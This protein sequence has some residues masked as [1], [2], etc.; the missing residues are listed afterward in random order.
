[1]D[2]SVIRFSNQSQEPIKA[3][4]LTLRRIQDELSPNL[5]YPLSSRC[6]GRHLHSSDRSRR[7]QGQQRDNQQVRGKRSPGRGEAFLSLA[8]VSDIFRSPAGERFAFVPVGSA[9]GSLRCRNSPGERF[10]LITMGSVSASISAA[11]TTPRIMRIV[12]ILL[13]DLLISGSTR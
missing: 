5:G 12:M 2:R 8:C 11:T 7:R 13:F 1:M 4:E 3:T 9:T 10:A 6:Y